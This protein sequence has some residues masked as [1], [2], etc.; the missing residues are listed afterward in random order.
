MTASGAPE[1]ERPAPPKR[2]P[3]GHE[4]R[5]GFAERYPK[6]HDCAVAIDELHREGCDVEE[7]ETCGGQRIGCSCCVICRAHRD[8][9]TWCVCGACIELAEAAHRAGTEDVNRVRYTEGVARGAPQCPGGDWRDGGEDLAGL[10][11]AEAA[12]PPL[13]RDRPT[14]APRVPR[15]DRG[16]RRIHVAGA[17]ERAP[18]APRE[19]DHA[20][21]D[22]GRPHWAWLHRGFYWPLW[23][24]GFKLGFDWRTLRPYEF[25]LFLGPLHLDASIV[26]PWEPSTYH[27]PTDPEVAPFLVAGTEQ[28]GRTL[29]EFDATT[30]PWTVTDGAGPEPRSET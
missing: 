2:I 26:H 10:L 19:G 27:P 16:D 18:A 24:F 6:C 11:R 25:A 29:H 17:G 21:S 12:R 3:Y 30:N 13:D 28:A 15:T 5:A 23:S 8:K 14:R 1:A 4:R 9:G 7:C 22:F 20:V